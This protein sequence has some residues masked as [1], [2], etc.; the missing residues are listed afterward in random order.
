MTGHRP[1]APSSERNKEPIALILAGYLPETGVV[2]EIASGLGQHVAWFAARFPGVAW[3]PTDV[4][5]EALAA[6]PLW[7]GDMENV[8]PPLQLD[9]TAGSWPVACAD[10]VYCANMIHIA[11][12]AAA[13]GLVAGA[14]RVLVPGGRLFIYGPF[15]QRGAHTAPSNAS[16]DRNLRAQNPAWGIRD[17]EAVEALGEPASLSLE[18]AHPMPANNLTLVFR[19]G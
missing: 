9:V 17:L 15:R 1:T 12:W 16:F 8:R 10:A 11:P 5:P 6:I 14:G 13:E 18:A 3:Q 7:A 2:L 19:K 4:D